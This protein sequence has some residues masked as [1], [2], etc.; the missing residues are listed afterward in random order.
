MIQ[1]VVKA[2]KILETV[3][4][5]PDG[6]I[7]LV[8]IARALGMEKPTAYNLIKTLLA[9]E[10]LAQDGPGGKYRIG[11]KLLKLP[12]GGLGDEFLSNIVRPLCE[13]ARKEIGENISL[14]AYRQ[15][16]VKIICRILCDNEIV[17]APNTF[18]PLYT[19]ISG[20][21]LLA[22][23]PEDQVRNVVELLGAPGELWNGNDNL[24]GL[25][26]ALVRIRVNGGTTLLSKERQLGGVGFIIDAPAPYHP[27]AIGSA[28]PLFRFTSKRKNVFATLRSCATRIS[29]LIKPQT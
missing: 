19:T 21:C 5:S 2:A 20:R 15:G 9:L 22:Q 3:H 6:C 29:N 7:R 28:M 13:E 12:Q 11:P 8:D 25:L 14:V 17:V 27:I 23:L 26:K 4:R 1:S 18:K 16:T 10:Y 24:T